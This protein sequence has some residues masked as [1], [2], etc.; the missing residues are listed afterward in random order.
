[1]HLSIQNSANHSAVLSPTKQY[2][3]AGTVSQRRCSPKITNSFLLSIITLISKRKLEF[4][5][6]KNGERVRFKSC[7]QL[8]SPQAIRTKLAVYMQILGEFV[9]TLKTIVL[10]CYSSVDHTI[11][12]TNKN[13]LQPQGLLHHFT[14]ALKRQEQSKCVL[15]YGS[16]FL[17]YPPNI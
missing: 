1:M 17:E 8:L 3:K 9:T 4:S 5:R 10:P 15:Q 2:G 14:M 13:R 11:L 12:L 6:L 16:F 7:A